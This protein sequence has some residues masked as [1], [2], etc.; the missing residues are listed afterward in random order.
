M[1]AAP[2]QIDQTCW[3]RIGSPLDI[4]YHNF[5]KILEAI[6]EDGAVSRNE[7][8]RVTLIIK[9]IKT[10]IES[11]LFQ[12]L[13]QVRVDNDCYLGPKHVKL[14][15]DN[16][17]YLDPKHVKIE[18]CSVW[19]KMPD[20]KLACS[21]LA[22]RDTTCE[23][24]KRDTACICVVDQVMELLLKCSDRTKT[25]KCDVPDNVIE[26]FDYINVVSAVMGVNVI[27]AGRPLY[28]NIM[29]FPL[30]VDKCHSLSR[31]T[32]GE[33]FLPKIKSGSLRLANMGLMHDGS[34]HQFMGIYMSDVLTHL[35]ALMEQHKKM[36]QLQKE[37][38][39]INFY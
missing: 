3:V 5:H 18:M 25:I 11:E 35:G 14:T 30:K 20:E 24:V 39:L 33:L 23:F 32:L 22:K 21:F 27:R 31:L 15:L 8:E 38:P 29:F 9:E 4:Y 7:T 26:E 16:D 2:N 10:T 37:Q 17:C 12:D 1:Q 19:S 34:L 36:T 6:Q 28:E 13:S